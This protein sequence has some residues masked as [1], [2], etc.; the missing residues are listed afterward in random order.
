VRLIPGAVPIGRSFPNYGVDALIHC[1]APNFKDEL[2]VEKFREFNS[3]CRSYVDDHKVSRL[4]VIGSWWQ[5]AEGECREISYTRLKNDQQALFREAVHVAPFSIFGDGLRE[6]RGFIPQLVEAI[7]SGGQLRGLSR[8]GRDFVHVNDVA[9]AVQLALACDPGCYHAG[10]GVVTSAK[11][12]A[13]SFG[14]DAPEFEEWPGAEPRYPV[15]PVPGW[16]PRIEL[17][18]YVSNAIGEASV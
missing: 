7:K 14:I 1:A 15:P 17:F 11:F 9:S 4:V 8:Q 6:G 3:S 10:T 2:A 18:Q 5:F 16:T 12:L 13:N